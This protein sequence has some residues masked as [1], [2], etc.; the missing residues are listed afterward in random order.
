MPG[1]WVMPCS[2]YI[3]PSTSISSLDPAATSPTGAWELEECNRGG[4]VPENIKIY[5]NLKLA[6]T[7]GWLN[8][9]AI[10]KESSSSLTS[11][12][13]VGLAFLDW[14]THTV[15]RFYLYPVFA[16]QLLL[17]S[18]LGQGLPEMATEPLE[19]ADRPLCIAMGVSWNGGTPKSS[20]LIGFS[21][22][23]HIKSSS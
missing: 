19:W 3:I 11:F 15:A 1:V 2:S 23:F 8:V 16:M 6:G 7:D 12:A 5:S 20:I 4:E 22:I 18:F 9:Q 17:I 10:F 14:M 21:W 13:I